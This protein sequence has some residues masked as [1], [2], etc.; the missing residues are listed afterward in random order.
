M[1]NDF[2]G[3][4]E[5]PFSLLPDPDFL[6]LSRQ[7]SMAAAMLEYGITNHSPITVITGEIG[8][9]KTTLIRHLLSRIQQ[10][11]VVGLLSNTHE[12]ME[13]ALPWVLAALEISCDASEPTKQ[14][15]AFNDFLIDQYALGH[16]VVLIIDE[17][18]NLRPDVLEEIRLLSNIN[19]DKHQVLQLVLAGQPELKDRLRQPS[20]KQFLQR[21]S[22][23]YHLGPLSLPDTNAYIKHRIK[24]ANGNSELF[25][26]EAIERIHGASEGVPRLINTL[27][28]TALVYA[29]ASQATVIDEDVINEVV[30]DRGA[31]GIFDSPGH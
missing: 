29:F 27:A 10:N 16:H 12:K 23:A 6:Y 11:V 1:Y 28:D 21:V 15:H 20:L 25:T 2:F 14:F 7:H 30:N 13:S 19:A 31:T 18:Q 9:G 4:T 8:A 17:A 3:F 5:K 22:V 24:K 26:P